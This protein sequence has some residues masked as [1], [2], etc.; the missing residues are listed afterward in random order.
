MLFRIYVDY[1]QIMCD[2]L[3]IFCH[4]SRVLTIMIHTQMV[5]YILIAY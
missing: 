4:I 1:I 5:F 2:D 3:L